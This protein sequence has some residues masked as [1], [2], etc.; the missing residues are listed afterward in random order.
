MYKLTK[1][2]ISLLLTAVVL[3]GAVSPETSYA[4]SKPVKKVV[5]K[6]ITDGKVIGSTIKAPSYNPHDYYVTVTLA[7]S[8]KKTKI[9]LK[10]PEIVPRGKTAPIKL[11]IGKKS[12]TIGKIKPYTGKNLYTGKNVRQA[13]VSLKSV[14]IKMGKKWKKVKLF[15]Y[16]SDPIQWYMKDFSLKKIPANTQIRIKF[17]ISTLYQW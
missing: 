7:K 3:A 13:N 4:A 5:V 8:S 12:V 17:G 10:Y 2:L 14:S 1:R 16:A 11:T 6:D 15:H 9:K